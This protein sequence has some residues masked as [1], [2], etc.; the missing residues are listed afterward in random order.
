[1]RSVAELRKMIEEVA[2][3]K[4]VCKRPLKFDTRRLIPYLDGSMTFGHIARK[5]G[6][7]TEKVRNFYNR[8]KNVYGLKY[9]STS[10][11][12]FVKDKT[13]KNHFYTQEE[14]I[15]IMK[16]IREG[17]KPKEISEKYNWGYE[18]TRSIYY[19]VKRGLENENKK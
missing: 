13:R 11:P 19:K 16:C 12:K 7:K 10:E 2:K 8:K 9:K 15:E 18:R 6:I 14:I 17:K 1:M 3:S 4:G 5:F